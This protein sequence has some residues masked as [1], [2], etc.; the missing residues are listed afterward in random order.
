MSP[1]EVGT[2]EG[3][4]DLVAVGL[5]VVGAEPV[6]AI[7][8]GDV[9]GVS[10]T[11][12][13][14]LEVGSTRPAAQHPPA[15]APVVG[16]IMVGFL[17]V[18]GA[19]DLRNGKHWSAGSLHSPELPEGSRRHPSGQLRH[20]LGVPLRHVEPAIGTPVEAV[21]SVLE[22]AQVAVDA[23]VLISDVVAIEIPY[24]GELRGIGHPQLTATP[25]ETLDGVETRCE[26]L[27]AIGF[28][29]RILIEQDPDRVPRGVR[30]RTP[31]LGPHADTGTPPRIKGDGAGITNQ[32]LPGK[33][34]HLDIAGRDGVVIR[35]RGETRY[36]CR[37]G[38]GEKE[39]FQ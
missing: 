14:N 13:D 27:A 31:V 26:A 8:E 22:I 34:L 33:E 37:K 32:R 39:L 15:H 10:E 18:G 1:A 24:H 30:F 6:E 25:G 11:A 17:V 19:A 36:P 3:G 2:V 38:D 21:E 23:N 20:P 29:I 35:R 28:T 5:V 12:R 9:P 4:E 16:R 7:V